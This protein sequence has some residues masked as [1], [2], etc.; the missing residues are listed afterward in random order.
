MTNSPSPAGRWLNGVLKEVKAGELTADFS[1]R[2]EMTNPMGILHGG[3][4]AAIIDEIIGTAVFSLG[5]ENFYSSVNLIIDFLAS[6]KKGETIT[7]RSKV[8]R[9]GKNIVNVACEVVNAEGKLL[10]RASSNLIATQTKVK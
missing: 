2:E 10:A 6:A 1:V 7:A 4:M 5:Q 9:Q 8:V 3:L